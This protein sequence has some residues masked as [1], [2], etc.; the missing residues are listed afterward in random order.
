MTVE[1]LPRPGWRESVA[2]A[3]DLAL[4]GIALSVGCL[5]VVGA[6]GALVT[7]SVAVDQAVAHRSFPSAARL[8]ETLRRTLLPGAAAAL[9]VAVPAVLLALDAIAVATGRVPGGAPLVL[10]TMLVAAG[11]V[12]VAG[13]ALVRLGQT[14][15]RGYRYSLRFAVRLLARRPSLAFAVVPTVLAPVLLAA[16]VPATAPLVPGFALFALHVVVRRFTAR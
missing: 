12:A 6:G 1:P 4:V 14:G 13:T 11:L 15:G 16:L 2:L 8:L 3:A 7:A 9:A 5:T 10:V